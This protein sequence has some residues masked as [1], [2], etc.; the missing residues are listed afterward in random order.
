MI[1]KLCH[2]YVCGAAL[3]LNAVIEW[4]IINLCHVYVGGAT[5]DVN[6]WWLLTS[7]MCM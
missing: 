3:Y 1:I 6:E 2:V 7:T 5:L 4:M